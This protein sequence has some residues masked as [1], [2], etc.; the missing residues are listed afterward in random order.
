MDYENTVKCK[1]AL[2][3]GST[4]SGSEITMY[5]YA[6]HRLTKKI[7]IPYML[8]K[9]KVGKEAAKLIL[10]NAYGLVID[11][12]SEG[13]TL[14]GL[15]SSIN[16]LISLRTKKV[17]LRG[18][19]PQGYAKGDCTLDKTKF[20]AMVK[21]MF[22]D[23]L[24][25]DIKIWLDCIEKGG[26]DNAVRKRIDMLHANN[27]FGEFCLM[28]HSLLEMKELDEDKFETLLKTLY[29]YE[30][31]E[32]RM[33][34]WRV[35]ESNHRYQDRNADNK[36]G[37]ADSKIGPHHKAG[38]F[39]LMHQLRNCWEHPARRYKRFL[40][41]VLLDEFPELLSDIQQ[42]LYDAGYLP[43]L[44]IENLDQLDTEDLD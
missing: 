20:V 21:G 38:A 10:L 31:W 27:I 35:L 43:Q 29:T 11:L 9:I 2:H 1:R 13:K 6:T 5:E 12:H 28:Y 36:T 25:D 16:F 23:D 39:G 18:I 41:A 26:H 4:S 3:F 42:A 44:D 14:K 32:S 37:S 8:N 33:F 22:G 30:G 40:L 7:T 34:N 24:P 15:F 17:T 19:E